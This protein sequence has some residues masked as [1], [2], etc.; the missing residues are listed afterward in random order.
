MTDLQFVEAVNKLGIQL[1]PEPAPFGDCQYQCMDDPALHKRASVSREEGLI[2]AD[3]AMGKTVLE[4][5]T[6][7]GVSTR[8]LSYGA[9]FV[10]S[11]DPDEW[12]IANIE[13]DMNTVIVPAIPLPSEGV[14]FDLAFIDGEHDGESVRRDIRE[15]LKVVKPGG[16]IAFHDVSQAQV[17]EVVDEF[18]WKTRKEFNTI[19]MLTVCEVP[20]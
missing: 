10:V 18:P 12:V 2:L 3:L 1:T 5:G 20:E 6:G 7:L 4:V 17:R 15:C 11:V 19:G 8:C 14:R 9:D 16:L 13:L